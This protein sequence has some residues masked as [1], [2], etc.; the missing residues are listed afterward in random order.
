MG[1]PTRRTA[2]RVMAI[3]H[4]SE[5]S[6][7]EIA[8]V[9]LARNLDRN[10]VDV[11]FLLLAPGPLER[12]LVGEGFAV[13]VVKV[14]SLVLT[15]DRASLGRVS[16][17]RLLGAAGLLRSVWKL[18]RLITEAHVDVVHVNSLKA[19]FLGGIA[20]R[21]ARVPLVWYVHDRIAGDYLPPRTARFV[22]LVIG[23]LPRFV[24]AN[25]F[26]TF[27]TLS[28]RAQTRGAVAYPGLEPVSFVPSVCSRSHID[29]PIVAS[30]GRISPTK[31]Q[32]VFIRAAAIVRKSHPSVRF[33]VAGAAMFNEQEYERQ[34]H[35]LSR[36][37]GLDDRLQ[38][39]GPVRDVKNLME[40]VTLV[41]HT[42]PVPEPFG[43]VVIEAMATGAPV[44][45]TDAGGVSEI[46]RRTGPDLAELGL[47][48]QPGDAV[49]L[50]NAIS[51]VL[52][53]P[54]DAEQRA[55]AAYAQVRDR[56]PISQTVQAVM[57]AWLRAAGLA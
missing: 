9:R 6:G 20:A 3:N 19:G 12:V 42:S 48:V 4:T 55:A 53:E 17:R 54:R 21:L 23:F 46:M 41:A 43:Q 36:E 14:S 47:L 44:V 16:A 26:A 57:N 29:P 11:S 33:V 22:R 5:L 25:S 45:V 35:S 7:A 31:G 50:A 39:L 34:L 1:Q 10:A 49:Q 27:S 37:L 40:N 8:L 38:F 28:Q 24:L 30:I 52:E 32:D 2:L 51:R 13:D 18:R 56:F 15:A